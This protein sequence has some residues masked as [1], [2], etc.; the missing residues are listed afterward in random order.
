MTGIKILAVQDLLL[1]IYN[2]ENDL[3]MHKVRDT[4]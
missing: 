4:E 3:K 1:A 2:S